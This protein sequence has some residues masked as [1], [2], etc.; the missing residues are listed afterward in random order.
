MID[1]NIKCVRAVLQPL[2][3]GSDIIG[4]LDHQWHNVKTEHA[5]GGL[6]L[7][8]FEHGLSIA[9]VEHDCEAVQLR[10]QLA[11]DL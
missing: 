8:H 4:P 11:S 1:R 2:K 9:N 6:R 3:R 5:C 7:A 10:D